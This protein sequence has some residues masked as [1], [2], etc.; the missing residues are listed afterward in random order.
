MHGRRVW[1]RSHGMLYLALLALVYTMATHARPANMSSL[2]DKNPSSKEENEILPPDHLN[3]VK[4]EMD[5]HLNKDFHQEVFLGKDMEE[6]EEDSEPRKNRKKLID[7]FSK[8]DF[9]GDQSISA[10]EMQRWIMEK[11]EEHFQEAVKENKLSFR[12]VDPDGDGHVTWDEYRVKFLASKGFNEK[13]VAEKLKNNEELKVDEETQEVLES[14]KD[15]WFQADNPPADQLLNEEEFLSF[16]HPE[17]SRG[18][19]KYMVKEIVRDLDQ[20]GDKKLTLSEFISLPMGTVENQQAQDVDDDWVRERKK[21]FQEVIDANQ[22]GIVTMEELEEY[23]DPMNEYNA[24]NEAKQMIAVAD[25][26]QNH[27]LELEEILKYS[28]Y[29]T[30]SKLMDY[31]RNV[32][33]EF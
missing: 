26:N 21:E 17:H 20:D 22:D 5:G 6:F 32:H 33:E 23:M 30:G 10:K 15:R 9:N 27:N 14:L 24:L 16:L 29:F 2:K 7:I 12:A 3:G 18:M 8:V 11:T 13:E 1:R 25:E 19:L 4:M 31:A 28:E